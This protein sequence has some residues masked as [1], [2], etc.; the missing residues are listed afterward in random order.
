MCL[1]CI[2]S[3]FVYYSQKCKRL[4]WFPAPFSSEGIGGPALVLLVIVVSKEVLRSECMLPLPHNKP[5]SHFLELKLLV[6]KKEQKIKTIKTHL[7]F[8]INR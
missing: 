2:L 5:A 1:S 8:C 3:L 6:N 7:C 4:V